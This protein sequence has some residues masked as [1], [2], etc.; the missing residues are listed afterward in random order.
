MGGRGLATGAVCTQGARGLHPERG[1]GL[2]PGGL[3]RPPELEKRAVC[4]ILECFLVYTVFSN[5]SNEISSSGS[6]V[7]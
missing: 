3:S 5:F 1:G 4:M 2:Q 6:I 7:G